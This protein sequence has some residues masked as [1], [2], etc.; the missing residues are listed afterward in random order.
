MNLNNM[1]SS[2]ILTKGVDVTNVESVDTY[3]RRIESSVCIRGESTSVLWR[4]VEVAFINKSLK[5]GGNVKR[6]SS[7]GYIKY[8]NESICLGDGWMHPEIT[9]DEAIKEIMKPPELK[10]AMSDLRNMKECWVCGNVGIGVEGQ[11][12]WGRLRYKTDRN[13]YDKYCDLCDVCVDK[14]VEKR[15]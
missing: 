6:G 15:I 4:G 1:H 13:L 12:N 9:R 3:L 5:K 10:Q 7:Y 11:K 14:I 8:S 2:L